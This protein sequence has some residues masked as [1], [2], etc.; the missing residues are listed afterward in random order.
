MYD[1]TTARRNAES[2]G[3]TLDENIASQMG[4]KLSDAGLTQ[5]QFDVA[6]WCHLWWVAPR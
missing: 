2:L 4:E 1:L 5:E 6:A 3:L